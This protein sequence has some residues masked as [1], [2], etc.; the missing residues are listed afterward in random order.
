MA[1]WRQTHAGHYTLLVS[2]LINPAGLVK[3]HPN[4]EEVVHPIHYNPPTRPKAVLWS[5]SGTDYLVVYLGD[6]LLFKKNGG[7]LSIIWQK[8][9]AW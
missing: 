9:C 7:N 6:I 8:T 3:N 4:P 5:S 1:A 2:Q